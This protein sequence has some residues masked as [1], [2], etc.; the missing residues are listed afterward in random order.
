MAGVAV[1]IAGQKGDVEIDSDPVIKVREVCQ[2]RPTLLLESREGTLGALNL[3][4]QG[5][6]LTDP[7]SEQVS[8]EHIATWVV[9]TVIKKSLIT[10]QTTGAVADDRS[11]EIK[12]LDSQLAGPRQESL[13][14][15]RIGSIVVRIQ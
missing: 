2:A 13:V 11:G 10:W 5:Q 9:V 15:R 1:P 4:R 6:D 7:F 8:D 3:P 12:T 14:N